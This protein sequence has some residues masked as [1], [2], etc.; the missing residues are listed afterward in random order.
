MLAG[1]SEGLR[2]FQPEK[3]EL[4]AELERTLRP[5]LDQMQ[6]LQA[7]VAEKLQGEAGGAAYRGC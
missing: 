6:R 4:L 3:D 7:G 1:A 5:D 2:A